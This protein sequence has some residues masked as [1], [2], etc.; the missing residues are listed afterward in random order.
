MFNYLIDDSGVLTGPVEF[1]LV[2]GIGVQR[3]SNAV[4]LSIELSPAPEGFAWAYDNGSLQ[5]KVDCRGDVYST[6]TGMRETW[7]ALGELPEGFTQLPWPGGFHI[8][9]DNAWQ[10]DEQAQLADHK[11]V[12]LI[13]R[14]ALLRDA[15][16]RIAPLQYAEDIGDAS[17]EEQ[18]QLLE[19]KLY[20]VELNRIE[21]QSGF[22]SLI[23]WPVAPGAAAN[24]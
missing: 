21:K 3:P 9:A 23:T 19:W 10:I 8:W 7:N 14:D 12:A 17:P 16:L 5:Q 15:V 6:E 18:L 11:R 24:T 20:S 13:K 22:P 2:P 1:P 4:A